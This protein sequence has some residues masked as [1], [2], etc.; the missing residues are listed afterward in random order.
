[1]LAGRI[2]L[3]SLSKIFLPTG[4]VNVNR[5]CGA[6]VATWGFGSSECQIM[7]NEALIK[8]AMALYQCRGD[9]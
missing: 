4:Q 2:G 1:M 9:G 7:S 8:M 6:N 3:L 5:G